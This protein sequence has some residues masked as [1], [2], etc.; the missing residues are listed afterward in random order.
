LAQVPDRCWLWLT[1]PS[2]HLAVTAPGAAVDVFAAEP[3]PAGDVVAFAAFDFVVVV[4]VVVDV[5]AAAPGAAAAAAGH[6]V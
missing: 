3:V 2:L 1:V 5:V 6:F 4:V